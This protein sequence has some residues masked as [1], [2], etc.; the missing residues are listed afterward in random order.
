MSGPPTAATPLLNAVL[1]A[2]LLLS[3]GVLVL[4]LVAYARRRTRSILLLVA[5]FAALCAHS[6]VAVLMLAGVVTES[7]H[8]LAEHTL[9]LV[10]SGLVLAAV[11]YARTVERAADE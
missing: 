1:L 11:Y 9:V 4:S 3:G 10:Q 6:L 8:H 5:A 2:C 7:T